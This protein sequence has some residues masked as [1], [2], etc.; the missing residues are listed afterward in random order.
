M[1]TVLRR[2]PGRWFTRLLFLFA[3]IA[4]LKRFLFGTVFGSLLSALAL[5]WAMSTFGESRPFT[6]DQLAIWFS[7]LPIESKTS[8]AASLLTVLGFVIAFHTATVY[9]KEQ[10]RTTLRIAA[11]EEIEHFFDEVARRTVDAQIYADSVISETTKAHASGFNPESVAAIDRLIANAPAFL[12]LRQRLT[13]MSV[14]VHRIPGK[15]YS[16]LLSLGGAVTALEDCAGAF[17][18]IAAAM[19]VHV[20][21]VAPQHPNRTAAF[22]YEID[23]QKWRNL[24]ACCER[25]YSFIS[26]LVAA[27]RGSL[28]T[29]IAEFNFAAL[30]HLLTNRT[31]FADALSEVRA[32]RP[33]KQ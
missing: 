20:P 23:L 3:P 30:R 9:W 1:L 27:I 5:Y 14:E 6:A 18:E 12:E 33:L 15:H 2:L 8:I 22:V 13:A 26:G 31:Q 16:L 7:D 11:A 4:L 10:T 25:N 21:V 32:N 19:W 29:P 24:S 17:S 28:L